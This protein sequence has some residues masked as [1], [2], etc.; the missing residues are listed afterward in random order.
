MSMSQEEE[1]RLS[2]IQCSHC[3]GLGFVMAISNICLQ[4][5]GYGSTYYGTPCEFCC[6]SGQVKAHPIK[7]QCTKCHGLGKKLKKSSNC[8]IS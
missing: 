2:S 8:I 1:V 6:T 5:S 7:K 4:C 3:K